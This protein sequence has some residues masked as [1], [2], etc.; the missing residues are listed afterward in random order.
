[1]ERI[2]VRAAERHAVPVVINRV[3]S[4]I[5]VF[6]TRE[7]VVDLASA[8]ATDTD[9]FSR[10]FHGLLSHGVYWPASNFEAAFLSTEIGPDELNLLEHAADFAFAQVA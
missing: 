2:L 4:M 3:G 9:L 6:F 5:T 1:V 10:W 8:S 7:P